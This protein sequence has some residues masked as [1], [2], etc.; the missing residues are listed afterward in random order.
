[1]L[2]LWI[3]HAQTIYFVVETLFINTKAKHVVK[4]V[5]TRSECVAR[6]AHVLDE[7]QALK[8]LG[9]VY[10][11]RWISSNKVVLLKL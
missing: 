7:A 9:D 11:T 3:R 1:M 2:K 6:D 5:D 8:R 10:E 4:V